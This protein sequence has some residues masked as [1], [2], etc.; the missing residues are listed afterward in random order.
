MT[1]IL[2]D[3]LLGQIMSLICGCDILQGRIHCEKTCILLL[4]YYTKKECVNT[5]KTFN[6][7]SYT[8][9]RLVLASVRAYVISAVYCSNTSSLYLFLSGDT[10]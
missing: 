8:N 3:T 10:Y 9:Y 1:H 4:Y 2:T 6:I 5:D 7:F